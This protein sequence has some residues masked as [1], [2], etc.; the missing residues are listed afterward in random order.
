MAAT[1]TSFR[2]ANGAV[3]KD[4]KIKMWNFD[5]LR[6]S[7]SLNL[8]KHVNV[9]SVSSSRPSLIQAVS[10]VRFLSLSPSSLHKVFVFLNLLYFSWISY[11]PITICRLSASFL[12][13]SVDLM[14]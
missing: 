5:G 10:T 6:F 2:A 13:T 1:T 3:L 8:T 11:R 4:P 7:D 14:S 12:T 9:F